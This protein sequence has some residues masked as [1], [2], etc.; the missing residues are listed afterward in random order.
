[1]LTHK[2]TRWEDDDATFSA[3]AY[4]VDGYDGVAWRVFGWETQP[5]DDTE[6]TGIEVR[7]GKVL[8]VMIGDDRRFA[9]DPEE[10]HPLNREEYCSECGQIGCTH[11]GLNRSDAAS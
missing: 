4:T 5:D 7:T 1:M 8:A 11:D 9:F 6:W 10:L 2:S 3:E